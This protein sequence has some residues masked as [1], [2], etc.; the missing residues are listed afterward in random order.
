MIPTK[1]IQKELFPVNANGKIHKI[2]LSNEL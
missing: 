1:W 2:E